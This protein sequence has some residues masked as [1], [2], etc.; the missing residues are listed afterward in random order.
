M[1]S[2]TPKKIWDLKCYPNGKK[3]CR[4][5]MLSCVVAVEIDGQFVAEK[6]G[7]E[8]DLSSSTCVRRAVVGRCE[9]HRRHVLKM[10]MHWVNTSWR[11]CRWKSSKCYND[12]GGVC[13]CWS[14]VPRRRR[15]EEAVDVVDREVFVEV[16]LALWRRKGYGRGK[17]EEKMEDVGGL[18]VVKEKEKRTKVVTVEGLFMALWIFVSFYFCFSFLFSF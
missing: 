7:V 4:Y 3:S 8:A 13:R 12:E 15:I 16:R 14:G 18:K 10:K 1:Q 11:R 2:Q 6:V 9:R 17:W 5:V